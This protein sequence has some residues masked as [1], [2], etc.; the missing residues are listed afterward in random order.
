[1]S[2]VSIPVSSIEFTDGGNTIWVHDR[3][4]GTALRIKTFG[5]ISVET[6]KMSP[7]SHCDLIVPTD[8]SFCLSDNARTE[9]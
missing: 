4:G 3:R 1:M 7:L 9:S 2:A 8:I 5:K 6:C